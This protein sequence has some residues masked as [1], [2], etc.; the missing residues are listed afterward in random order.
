MP[1]ISPLTIE[2]IRET[3]DIL[4]VVSD[5]VQLKKRGKDYVANC[6]FHNEKSPSFHVNPVKGFYKCFGCGKGGD[7]I[8]FIM[9]IEKAGYVEALRWL[10]SKYHIPIENDGISETDSES[11]GQRERESLA[12]VMKFAAQF[13]QNNLLTDPNGKAI[14]LS[15]FKERGFNDKS[16]ETFGLGYSLDA[17]DGLLKAATKAGHTVE[18]LEKA[19][20]IIIKE[21][22]TFDRFRARVMFPI[23]NASGKVIAFGA[24]MLGKDKT[25]PKY[26]NSPETALYHKSDVL[27]GLFQAKQSIRNEDLVYLCEGYTDVIS[28]HQAGIK[29]VVATSGTALTESQIKL[30]SRYSKNITVL[31]DGDLAGIKASVRGI[32]MLLEAGLNVRAVSFPD[33]QD[34]DSYLNT[35]GTID[36]TA[37]LKNNSHDFITFKANLFAKEAADDPFKRASIIRDMVE[38]ISKIPEPLTRMVF[39]KQ[40]AEVFQV[41]EDMLIAEANKIKLKSDQK[42]ANRQRNSSEGFQPNRTDAPFPYPTD[43]FPSQNFGPPV[44]ETNGNMPGPE[45]YNFQE[46]PNWTE[47]PISAPWESD[48]AIV[49]YEGNNVGTDQAQFAVEVAA[50]QTNSAHLADHT[51]AI[52]EKACLRLLLNYADITLTNELLIAHYYLSELNEI[53][54][55]TPI[56]ARMFNHFKEFV[57]RGELPPPD[58]F[59]SH[60][61]PDIARAAIDLFMEQNTVSE[62]WKDKHGIHIPEERSVAKSLA[63]QNILG[64][65]MALLKK[66]TAETLQELRKAPSEMVEDYLIM[67]M[68]LKKAETA[69]AE[70]LGNVIA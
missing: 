28:L 42:Q 25:Q 49:G 35:V 22:K 3:A 61:E 10:A 65:K 30:V 41:P 29:N 19:G 40:C 26:L 55:V 1:P 43:S 14:G 56:Y 66:R 44:P 37:W 12:I 38:S 7:S 57:E 54:F 4:E 16:I 15:Y 18:L 59:T 24:R 58:F 50:N 47:A 23:H 33:G 68:Q 20:L 39:F 60:S 27:Y 62:N 5:F 9:E 6:P 2:R 21:N 67:L 17:W 32:D 53:S 64:I 63:Y 31:Y 70:L 36:F 11:A 48:Y 34:P 51:L 69:I 45:D 52:Q 46:P 8:S 13:Y